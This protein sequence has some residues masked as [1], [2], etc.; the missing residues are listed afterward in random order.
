MDKQV[1]TIRQ[2]LKKAS[3]RQ[4]SYANLKRSTQVFKEGDKVFLRVK[5][6]KSS[7]KL[8]EHK[9]LSFRSCG[10]YSI[11][12]GIGEKVYKLELPPH[13]CVHNVS[14]VSFLKHYVANPSHMLDDED[15]ILISQGEF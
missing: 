11:V 13:L 5:P 10:P 15:T 9:K 1:Q 3:D 14:Y 2:S 6:K 12:K 7:L 4:K 8:G